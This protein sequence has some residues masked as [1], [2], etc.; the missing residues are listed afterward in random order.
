M[1]F[2]LLQVGQIVAQRLQLPIVSSVYGS[3]D[4]NLTFLLAMIEKTV[5]EI[6]DEFP[7]PQLTREHTFT[8]STGVATYD[9]PSDYDTRLN[10]T[11]WNRTQAWPMIG[12]IDAVEWQQYKSGLIVTLPRQRFRVFGFPTAKFT[13]D[14][15]PT[16]SENGQ[17][18]VFEYVSAHAIQTGTGPAT[19]G[20]RFTADTNT[21]LLDDWMIV[22]GTVW[23]YKRERNQEYEDLRRDAEAQIETAKTKIMGAGVL[24]INGLRINSPMI[25]VW[26]YPEGNYGI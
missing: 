19:Y 11:I 5:N 1:T 18:C 15:T 13:I 16:S 4:N 8:L 20:Q 7:W 2:T 21:I 24:T 9:L 10:A 12:P 23:R 22:D 17:T 3:T 25:G 26:S 14:P 6:K